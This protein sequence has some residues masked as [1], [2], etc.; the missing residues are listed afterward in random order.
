[1][2]I[3][4]SS[5]PGL[6]HLI[7]YNKLTKDQW[8]KHEE[9]VASNADLKSE[10]EGF[11]DDAYKV[12]KGT[13]VALNTYENLFVKFRAQYNKDVKK[14]LGSLKV[15]QDAV[16]E[17]PSLNKKVIKAIE[18]YIKNSTNL[19]ELLTAAI[20]SDISSLKQDTSDIKSMMFE[21]LCAFKGQTPPS[22]T[23]PT[24]TLAIT[25]G[26]WPLRLQPSYAAGPF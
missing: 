19:N 11:H 14:I 8:E 6:V 4:Q 5:G 10:I 16:K 9:A 25:R 17:D 2:P 18:S 7:I 24:T 22:S 1:G 26:P 21:I 12:H 23:M 20:Q 3:P 13:Q 15:I